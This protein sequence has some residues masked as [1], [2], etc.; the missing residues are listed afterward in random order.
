MRHRNKYL[1]LSLFAVIFIIA[2]FESLRVS[3][4]ISLPIAAI[5]AV[6]YSIITGIKDYNTFFL[7][8]KASEKKRGDVYRI[9]MSEPYKLFFERPSTSSTELDPFN[10]ENPSLAFKSI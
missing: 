7:K 2:F 10:L 1:F 6:I 9:I 3:L 5:P 8:G 4:V